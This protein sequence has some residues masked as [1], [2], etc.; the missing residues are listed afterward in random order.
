MKKYKNNYKLRR[1]A[2]N[3]LPYTIIVKWND[4]TETNTVTKLC[5]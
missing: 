5:F 3:L 1:E 2:N 4:T